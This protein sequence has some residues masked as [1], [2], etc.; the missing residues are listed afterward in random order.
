MKCNVSSSEK[1]TLKELS[2]RDDIVIKVS[3]KDHQFVISS[4]E[5]YVEKVEGMLADPKTYHML[6]KN[7]LPKMVSEIDDL[8][9]FLAPKYPWIKEKCSPYLPRIP[10]FYCTWKTHTPCN[11][12]S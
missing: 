9:C 12:T 6:N 3:D 1:K 10:E 7:P 8:I 5:T 11:I 2:E 4:K